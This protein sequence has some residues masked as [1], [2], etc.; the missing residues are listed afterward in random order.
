MHLSCGRLLSVALL[1]AGAF[2]AGLLCA[3]GGGL[4][5]A[6]RSEEL[7]F[8][9]SPRGT[10]PAQQGR[11]TRDP[12]GSTETAPEEAPPTNPGA[13][14]VYGGDGNGGGAANG[15]IAVTGSYGVGTSV[16]Y[17][18]DTEQR[19]LAVYEARGGS[20]NSRRLV[21]VGARRVDLDLRLEAY[22]DDSEYQYRDLLD[23]FARR[24]NA[25]AAGPTGS[26]APGE[27]SAAGSATS[28]GG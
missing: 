21:F 8:A 1:V 20:T 7:R 11:G 22:N 24:G 13:P 23:E 6:K 19:Q 16:L 27:P 15:F 9:P 12:I 3:P 18:L 10:G 2:G 14:L 28:S 4:L 17:V 5:A 25:P 26:V